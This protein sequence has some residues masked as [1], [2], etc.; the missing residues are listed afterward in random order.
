MGRAAVRHRRDDLAVSVKATPAGEAERF[1]KF[2]EALASLDAEAGA[3]LNEAL[4]T[5]GDRPELQ[6]LQAIADRGRWRSRRTSIG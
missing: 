1:R 4:G 6:W 5:L 2:P 3:A